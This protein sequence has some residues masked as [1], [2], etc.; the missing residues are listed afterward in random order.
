MQKRPVV[1]RI[2]PRAFLVFIFRQHEI[3]PTFV[4]TKEQQQQFAHDWSVLQTVLVWRCFF[5]LP[6]YSLHAEMKERHLIHVLFF[7]TFQKFAKNSLDSRMET[8]LMM[9]SQCF[10]Q[11]PR[12]SGE[13]RDTKQMAQ[14][15]NTGG[16]FS[17]YDNHQNDKWLKVRHR[18]S[19][20]NLNSKIQMK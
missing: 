17:G 5:L 1:V 16:K 20:E 15:A 8:W 14:I 19:N 6:A 4:S 7:V 18:Q 9:W 12:G 3:W 10:P 13:Q 11:T 2:L